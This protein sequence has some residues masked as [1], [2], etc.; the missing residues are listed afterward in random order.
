MK[1]TRRSFLTKSALATATVAFSAKSWSQ[2][3]SANSDLRV[4]TVGF[5]GRG[6]D[7]ISNMAKLKGVRF[8]ALCDADQNV[9]DSGA[10]KLQKDGATI[11]KFKDIRKL[12]EKK[13]L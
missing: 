7:H 9:L 2:V 5:N 3:P 12:L 6:G 1:T 8:S 10:S 4:A 13:D 11:E